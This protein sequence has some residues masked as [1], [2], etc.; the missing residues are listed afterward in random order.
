VFHAVAGSLVTSGAIMMIIDVFKTDSYVDS[1]VFKDCTGGCSAI[2][3]YNHE[4]HVAF[5]EL[6]KKK[7]SDEKIKAINNF[8]THEQEVNKYCHPVCRKYLDEHIRTDQRNEIG[9]P[10]KL[11]AGVRLCDFIMLCA[12]DYMS[13]SRR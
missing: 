10:L 12:F 13:L 7:L 6:I 2:F 5:W 3:V 1:I 9:F 11:A 8:D 4:Y